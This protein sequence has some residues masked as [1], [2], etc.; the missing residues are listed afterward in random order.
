MGYLCEECLRKRNLIS[1]FLD[2]NPN[3]PVVDFKIF[4]KFM[5]TAD[6]PHEYYGPVKT[7]KVPAWL[8]VAGYAD[9]HQN[10]FEKSR[11]IVKTFITLCANNE[12]IAKEAESY[13]LLTN[14]L[15]EMWYHGSTIA[16]LADKIE[17]FLSTLD[18]KK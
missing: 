8:S 11:N 5:E 13:L 9:I 6:C 1:N 15:S 3:E 10:G 7:Y 16:E 17:Y 14:V 12:D 4:G 18:D 2:Y